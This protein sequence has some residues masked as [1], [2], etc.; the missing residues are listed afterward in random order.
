MNDNQGDL[1]PETTEDQAA[2]LAGVAALTERIEQLEQALLEVMERKP[3]EAVLGVAQPA[4]TIGRIVRYHTA[5]KTY[6]AI[7]TAVHP[8]EEQLVDLVI[9][10][11]PLGSVGTRLNVRPGGAKQNNTW[12]WPEI[13]PPVDE[14]AG[15]EDA[16]G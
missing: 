11:S 9:F 13:L 1:M 7:V 14:V 12:S 5:V 6:P 2:L 16:E 8:V 3:E 15:E 4:L 10:G